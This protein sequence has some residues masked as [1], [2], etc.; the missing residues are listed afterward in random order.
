LTDKRIGKGTFVLATNS[1]GK[2]IN[3]I[4][5]NTGGTTKHVAGPWKKGYE[6]GTYGFDSNTGTAWAVIN[7]NGQFAAATLDN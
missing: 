6:L 1:K 2:W 7:Y 4:D 5:K 3:A